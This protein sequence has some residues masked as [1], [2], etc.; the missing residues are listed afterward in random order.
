MTLVFD[1]ED[2][3]ETKIMKL[4]K[5]VIVSVTKFAIIVILMLMV[6]LAIAI[7]TVRKNVTGATNMFGTTCKRTHV[8]LH[9]SVY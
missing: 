6:G 2:G 8:A 9:Q 4:T 1:R 3:Q 7:W 5:L